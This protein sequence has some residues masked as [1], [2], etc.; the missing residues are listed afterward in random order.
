MSTSFVGVRIPQN[1][2]LT[3]IVP[4]NEHHPRFLAGHYGSSANFLEGEEGIGVTKIL[5]A[6]VVQN[7]VLVPLKSVITSW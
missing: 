2:C 1:Y 7:L 3:G 6:P 5:L 4:G